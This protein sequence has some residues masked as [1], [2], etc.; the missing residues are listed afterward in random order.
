VVHFGH[1][2][3]SI[4]DSVIAEL[5]AIVGDAEI[6]ILTPELNAG[7]SVEVAT[8][9]FQGFQALVARVTPRRQRVSV[10]LDFLG[11]QT[12]VELS[13]NQVVQP[14]Q[15]IRASVVQSTSSLKRES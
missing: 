6:K 14:G 9:V 13:T 1:R 12:A 7:D 8:G 4:P 5:R 15:T 11:R 3:P 10:L 2:W